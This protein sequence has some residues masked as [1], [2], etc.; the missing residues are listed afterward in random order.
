MLK[1][2][3]TTKITVVAVG[4]LLLT[5]CGG[6]SAQPQGTAQEPKTP[7]KISVFVNGGAGLPTPDKDVILQRLN[8]DLNMDMEFNAPASDYD[9]QLSVKIAG[10]TPP[11]L[12]NVSKESMEQYA[13]QGV[14][15]EIGKYIDRMPNVKQKW[16]ADELNKGKVDGK[17]YA[18]PKRP[19]IPINNTY[20]IRKDWLD[21]VGL[22]VP[23]NTEELLKVAEA[24]TYKDPDGN[25]K[26]D[27]F[28]LTGLQLAGTSPFLPI[29][30]AYGSPG[31]G[32]IMIKNNKPVYSTIEPEFKE[33]LAAIKKFVQAKVVDPEFMANTGT[34][35]DE[36][37]YKGQAG[38]NYAHWARMTKETNVAV[39]KAVNPNAE[40]QQMDALTGPGGKYQ[41]Y[42]D[43]GAA[44]GFIAL[45]SSLEKQPEKLAKVLAYIDYVSGGKGE[46]LVN[47]GIEGQH[48]AL[49]DGKV[50]VLPASS[51]VV[52]SFIHQITNRDDYEYL[53]VKFPTL[54]PYY[55]FAMKQPYLKVYTSFVS[56][57][58]TMNAADLKRYEEAEIIKF[59]YGQRP[60]EEFD[61][62]VKTIKDTY[63]I[64][65][66]LAEAEAKLKDVGIIK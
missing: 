30:S 4:S 63:K 25:G 60:L 65:A 12:F 5:A 59:I 39:Y 35:A 34:K 28:G 45:P 40:W 32:H 13:K 8:Q 17:V 23:T 43:M 15:L 52:Y 27:T 16:P 31:R 9:Q 44:P 48:Y 19:L 18:L 37:A 53:K 24:F 47:Y 55:N 58:A 14:L 1:Q 61:Q 6:Q 50:E 3:W 11:D 62:F 42:V 51:E 36:K 56:F 26:Q 64:D 29:W 46:Q 38:I 41:G 2:T 21:K 57:P 33:S 22:A 49:K 7:V 10:G 20:F 66:Y 54:E